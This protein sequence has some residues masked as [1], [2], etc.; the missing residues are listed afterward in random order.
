MQKL[1]SL[2]YQVLLNRKVLLHWRVI[3]LV[4]FLYLSLSANVSAQNKIWDK[5]FGGD[6][7]DG[8][9]ALQQTRDGGYI[10]GGYSGSDISGDKTE[11]SKGESD[12]WVVKLRADGSKE[13][14]KTIGG[15]RN[16]FLSSLQQTKDGGYILGGW[17]DSRKSGD[18]TQDNRGEDYTTDYWIV[19]LNADGNKEWDKTFGGGWNDYLQSIQ[20]TPDGGYIIGGTSMSGLS[21]DKT[22][23]E[24]GI[25]LV[26]LKADGNKVWDKVIAGGEFSSLHQNRDGSYILGGTYSDYID[27]NTYGDFWIIKLKADGSKIW[28][29]TFGGNNGE[30][31]SALQQTKDDGYI[32]GGTSSSGIS[33]DKTEASKGEG[34]YWVVK[35][36]ADGTKEWDK[37]FGGSTQDRLRALQQTSDDSYVL[38]GTSDSGISGDKTEANRGGQE[39]FGSLTDDYWLVKI[40]ANGS[41]IW[42]KTFGGN[43]SDRLS[44][45]Q[46]TKD[47]SF[48][49]GGTSQS[50]IS[51]D[52]TEANKGCCNYWIIKLENSDTNISQYVT[53]APIS[54]KSLGEAPFTLKA[55]ASSGLPVTFIVVSGPAKVKG[56]ILTLTGTGTVTL[57]A[58]QA[59]NATYGPAEA[60]QTIEVEAP[61][62]LKKQWDKT[63]GGYDHDVLT[64]SQQTRDGGYILGGYSWS[65]KSGDKSEPNKGCGDGG[66]YTDYW[67]VKL[68]A[69][70]TKEWDKTIG[71]TYIDFLASIQQTRD[72]GYI[73]GGS[74]RSDKS[75]DKSQDYVND[76]NG[77]WT[78]DYWIV[79]LKADGT[80]E[81]D[82]TSGGNSDDNLSSVQQTSDGGYILGGASSSNISKDKTAG[83]KGEKDI[84]G[85]PTTDYWVVKLNAAGNKEW[86]ET[87]GGNSGD[88][89]SS[90]QQTSDGGY[91]LGG[92]SFSGKSADKSEASRG[93]GDYWIVKLKASG[94]KEW[95]KTFGGDYSDDLSSIKQTN[96]GG[97]LLGGT[98]FSGKSGDKTESNKGEKDGNGNPTQDYWVV[99][100]MANGTKVWDKTLGGVKSDWFSSVQQTND[101]GYIVGGTSDSDISG[102]KTHFNR[103]SG[104]Y[105]IVKLRADGSKEWDKT[106][107]GDGWDALTSLQQ[108]RDG[109]YLLGGYSESGIGLDKSE[110]IAPCGYGCDPDYW[111][112]K[113]M[114]DEPLEVQWDMR[115]GGLGK[116]NLTTVIKTSDGGYLSGGFTTSGISGDKT[117]SSQDKNDYWIVKSDKNGKKLW[118]KR[119]GGTG[120]DYLN[121]VIQ[122][123]DGGYLLGGSS[124]SGKSGDKSEASQGEQDYWVVKLDKQG[125][126]EWDK[127]FGGSGYD[128]LKKVVQLASGEYVLGGTSNSPVSRDISQTSQGNTDYW[129]VK[130]SK[131]GAKLWDK[132]YGGSAD[133]TLGSFT[134]TTDGGFFLGGSSESG[135]SGDKN[136]ASQGKSDYWTVKTDKDGNLLWEKS[137]GGSGVDEVYSVGRSHGENLFI[138]GTSSSD[139][140]GD[141]SQTSQGGKDYWLIKLDENGTKLWDKS[142]GGSKDDELRAST[143]TDE[144]HYIL[145]GTSYSDNS[146]NK[147]QASQGTSDYWVV[148]VAPSGEK[149]ADQRFGGSGQDELSTVFQT[150]DGG[151]LLG[152]S[153]DSGVSGNRTQPS[154]G[155]TDYWLVK[156]APPTTSLAAAREVI[157]PAEL[158]PAT[159]LVNL[160]AYPNPFNE[161][162]KV[163]FTLPQTQPVQVKVYDSQGKEITTLFRDEAKAGQ[164]YELEWQASNKPAGIYLL[165]L[166][167]PTLRQ[168]QKLLLTK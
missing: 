13:W 104:D 9:G 58:Y 19:K 138:A 100:L 20:Q 80:K 86:D 41:K 127:T 73:L 49:L 124:L 62:V 142:F 14:D 67:V 37:T 162:V 111:I 75:G 145:A 84:N 5:T 105:W 89:L 161:Q 119:Y 53:F 76:P 22:E 94:S 133:E 131:S 57:K 155:S 144:G 116:D 141:K 51:G 77:N 129:L 64:S 60:I 99:K 148:E 65:G 71:G 38:G 46:Q 40:D 120:D 107:G 166:Q 56:N 123:L 147:S 42:D 108:T 95:D 17:S 50:G 63:Y 47:G 18:R 165:Q 23:A 1:L 154:Q 74:S 83:N 34:D 25:W 24:I 3:N 70:G 168:Q 48:I 101:G 61:S 160:A 109:G 12:Y 110:D 31:L 112:V 137:F 85:V 163:S 15:D 158:A 140:E 130:I 27:L 32:L 4:L 45:L 92:T 122:T 98:S 39:D 164:K 113:L 69:D 106:I 167:T 102:D 156:V 117:Q 128:E 35:L 52:K 87:I 29:K 126:K 143:F 43:D 159:N 96:D 118:D 151:L 11:A 121:R 136:Q 26:K 135:K 125:K 139:K 152:G 150:S 55:T 157:E 134:E 6:N 33:G 132:T 115:Y 88:N 7:G 97:Y 78:Y 90:V 72:G 153:S 16:D 10:L 68:K 146:G 79:K 44:A 36:K 59:G 28:D 103:G 93:S 30:H 149:V 114:V 66:C 21:G 91:I 2:F 54:Y 81:W 8:L 82:K